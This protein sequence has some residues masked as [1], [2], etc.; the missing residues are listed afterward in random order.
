MNSGMNRNTRRAVCFVTTHKTHDIPQSEG[1]TGEAAGQA[2]VQSGPE[3]KGTK[4]D[5]VL[6]L[7]A[8]ECS[9]CV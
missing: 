4:S 7:S 8:H 6:G 9:M 3:V 1:G 2:R 5:T